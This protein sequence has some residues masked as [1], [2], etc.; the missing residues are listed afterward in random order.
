VVS[1]VKA[2]EE[3]PELVLPGEVVSDVKAAEEATPE[4][5]LPTGE[6]TTE[7]DVSLTVEVFVELVT[8]MEAAEEAILPE[9]GVLASKDVLGVD[10]LV[11]DILG[12]D[13]LGDTLVESPDSSPSCS[14]ETYHA[15]KISNNRTRIYI[16]IQN[17]ICTSILYEF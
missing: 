13:A 10:V 12:V 2:A 8:G 5:V 6:A 1:G 16:L 14:V 15:N 11:S 9:L 3:A 4:L 7:L 17:I